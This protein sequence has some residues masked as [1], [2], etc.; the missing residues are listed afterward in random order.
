MQSG[1]QRHLNIPSFFKDSGPNGPIGKA[2]SG[3]N[4]RLAQGHFLPTI[5]YEA[6]I[7]S[8]ILLFYLGRPSTIFFAIWAIAV[9]SIQ[10]MILAWARPHVGKERGK[11]IDPPVA[12]LN[13]TTTVKMKIWIIWICTS[14]LHASPSEI[15]WR[16]AH[17]VGFGIGR[18]GFYAETSA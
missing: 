16:T 6:V 15:F 12:N 17:A 11:I 2:R 8:V 9:N 4:I 13:A 1:T 18:Y 14:A 7:S 10:R 5:N 3:L